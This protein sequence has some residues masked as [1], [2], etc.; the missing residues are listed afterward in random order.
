VPDNRRAERR[1][2]ARLEACGPQVQCSGW[3]T[4]ATVASALRQATVALF[5]SHAETYGLALLEAMAAG[6]A[7]VA[8]DAAGHRG[9]LQ[10]E[11]AG[12]PSGLLVPVAQP[13]AMA[14]AAVA[15]LNDPIRSAA[16]GASAAQRAERRSWAALWPRWQTWYAALGASPER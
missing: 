15:L 5:P 12:R 13:H 14:A 16:L 6:A 4:P 1:W 7:I 11:P 2:R 8:T 10:N 3:A 9:L